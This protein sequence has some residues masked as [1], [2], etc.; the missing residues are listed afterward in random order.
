M[1]KIF[2]SALTILSLTFGLISC[3][4]EEDPAQ[5]LYVNFGVTATIT[6]KI[7]INEDETSAHPS[8]KA[9]ASV[10]FIATVPYS[11]LNNR[12]TGTYVIPKE[13]IS[14]DS[15]TGVFEVKSPVSAEGSVITVKFLDF[16]GTVRKY[17]SGTS[18]SVKVIWNSQSKSS[19]KVFP[20]E[21]YNLSSWLFD[22]TGYVKDVSAGDDI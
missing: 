11:D 22:G 7:L 8:W 1:K 21:T 3:S 19:V 2:L 4:S 12:A 9:P 14:Y 16:K 15:G 20:G 6:G 13:N 17:I 5:S 18:Q 10:S